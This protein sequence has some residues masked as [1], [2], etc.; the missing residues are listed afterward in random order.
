MTKYARV[1]SFDWF[2]SV[3]Q[4]NSSSNM[5]S[6]VSSS[7]SGSDRANVPRVA[8]SGDGI[9]E[10]RSRS[11]SAGR[12][13]CTS[14]DS[15]AINELLEGRMALSVTLPNSA[16][17]IV[18]NVERRTPMLDLLVNISTQYRFT[19]ANYT[20]NADGHEFKA[21]TPIGSLDVNQISIIPKGV[22]KSASIKSSATPGMPFKTTF[23][24]QV[25]LPRNQ[26]MVMRVSPNATIAAIK[27][28][29]CSEKA[30]DANKYLLVRFAGKSLGPQVLDSDKTLAYYTLN[31]VTLIS[32]KSLAQIELQYG[33]PSASDVTDMSGARST[34]VE[35]VTKKPTNSLIISQSNPDF[36]TIDEKTVLAHASH[37]KNTKKRPAP[38]PPVSSS[39]TLPNRSFSV[40]NSANKEENVVEK[41]KNESNVRLT[42]VSSILNKVVKSVPKVL[43]SVTHVRHNSGSDSSGYHESVLSSD[44][45]ESSSAPA[46]HQ[47]ATDQSKRPS[48]TTDTTSNT[49]KAAAKK[50][51]APPPPPTNQSTDNCSAKPNNGITDDN[52]D[53]GE[54]G[55]SNDCSVDESKLVSECMSDVSLPLSTSS[56]SSGTASDMNNRSLSPIVITQNNGSSTPLQRSVVCDRKSLNCDSIRCSSASDKTFDND[57]NESKRFNQ[58]D[59]QT[60]HSSQLKDSTEPT[61]CVSCVSAD[62]DEEVYENPSEAKDESESES[63]GQPG[64]V[65]SET[66]AH[67]PAVSQEPENSGHECSEQVVEPKSANSNDNQ[68]SSS[69][70]NSPD[71]SNDIC[72]GIHSFY[73]SRVLAH[74]Y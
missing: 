41:N 5:K 38:P 12:M 48:V 44:S 14:D 53:N 22:H 58:T 16:N 13:S 1:L 72:D 40:Q 63:N 45:P 52:G 29:I 10:T 30:L 43:K 9:E 17:P 11:R 26:L 62:A 50:R 49:K 31:E 27:Q 61:S 69:N 47:T 33:T 37:S 3:T 21:S 51:R 65:V 19:A 56:S 35:S 36:S 32:N 8:T 60:Q 15:C 25:N 64:V 28:I 39:A 34:T 42:D 23:R 57:S 70:G 71:V 54:K 24:L 46:L 67:T 2:F 18:V 20:I 68:E 4:S 55:A 66:P 59:V 7:S 74:F 6:A 73:I